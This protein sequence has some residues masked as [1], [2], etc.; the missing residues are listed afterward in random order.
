MANTFSSL[1]YHVVFS[2][3][4]R[5]RWITAEIEDRVWGYMA[6]IAVE[7]RM[8]PVKI[9]G[10]DDHVHLLL[11]VPAAMGPSKAVQFI[12]GGSS[13]WIHKTFPHMKGFNWQDGYGVFT[14]SKSTVAEVEEYIGKQREHHRKRT[15]QEEYRAFLERHEVVYDERYVWG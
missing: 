1:F 4:N 13:L 8:H 11:Q 5:E 9:G 10:T 15:F 3:K 12:K 2:T 14:V 7:N 6:G